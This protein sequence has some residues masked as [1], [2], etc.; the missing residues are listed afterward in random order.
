MTSPTPLSLGDNTTKPNATSQAAHE[1]PCHSEEYAKKVSKTIEEL[2][3]EAAELVQRSSQAL[4][5]Q[6]DQLRAQAI[7]ARE[8]TLSY[9]QHEPAKALLIAAGVGAALVFLGNWIGHRNKR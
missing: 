7:K 6:S 5:Q 4:Q 3:A 9:V 1:A 8:S 2:K